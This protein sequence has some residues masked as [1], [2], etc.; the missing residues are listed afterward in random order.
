MQLTS[1]QEELS[2]LQTHLNALQIRTLSLHATIEAIHDL[3]AHLTPSI[4]PTGTRLISVDPSNASDTIS[5]LTGDGDLNTLGRV[6]LECADR[7]T[8]E[9]AAFETRL[10]HASLDQPIEDL[11]GI[12]HGIL[13]EGLK[14]ETVRYPPPDPTQQPGCACCRG[15]PD[16]VILCSFHHGNALFFWESEYRALWG[17]ERDTGFR[18]GLGECW[19]MATREQVERKIKEKDIAESKL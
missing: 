14:N 2:P 12:S 5:T 15:D 1:S 3:L 18:G 8:R 13:R 7:C 10:L 19:L 6:F 9:H 17:D 11:Y 16:A 4:S